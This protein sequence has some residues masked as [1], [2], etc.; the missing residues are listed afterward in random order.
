MFAVKLAGWLDPTDDAIDL[1]ARQPDAGGWSRERIVVKSGQRVRL[2][3]RSEDVVHGFAIGRL[4]VDA[5]L[6]EP[7][8]VTTVEFVANG[9]GEFTYLSLIHI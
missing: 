1:V 5:G 2:R 6:I 9:T 4:G 3:I 7:G 8:K